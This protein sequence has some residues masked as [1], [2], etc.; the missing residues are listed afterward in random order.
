M[1]RII[2]AAD[3]SAIYVTAD[4]DMVDLIAYR[5]YGKHAKNTE[6]IF[7]ANP[8]LAG[9]GPVLPAGVAVKLPQMPQPSSTTP[10]RQLWD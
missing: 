1:E 6:A 3:G 7:E 10:F 5:Y 4:G 9:L 2:T 8:G